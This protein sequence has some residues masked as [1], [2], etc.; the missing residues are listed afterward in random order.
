MERART[1]F[2]AGT[3]YDGHVS[4]VNKDL[5]GAMKMNKPLK[6]IG[7]ILKVALPADPSTDYFWEVGFSNQSVLKPYGEAEFS[8]T[9]TGLGAKESQLWHFEAIG[10]DETG[11][12]LAHQRSFEEEDVDRNAFQ[13]E[14]MVKEKRRT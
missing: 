4:R 8:G 10:G 9:D 1:D 2:V 12:V 14:V 5:N 6:K 11:L 7:D 3:F 13:V